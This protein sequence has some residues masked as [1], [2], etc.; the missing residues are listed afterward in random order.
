M[1]VLKRIEEIDKELAGL[2][3][4]TASV[5]DSDV[6]LSNMI[7]RL[8]MVRDDDGEEWLGPYELQDLDSDDIPFRANNE[9]FVEAKPYTGPAGAKWIEWDG[10]RPASINDDDF[11]LFQDD[12]GGVFGRYAGNLIWDRVGMLRYV[13]RYTVI[14]P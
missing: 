9:W 6:D 11:V 8:V 2:K 12:D 14:E 13:T 5:D 7:G 1:D 4:Q 10:L 3:R